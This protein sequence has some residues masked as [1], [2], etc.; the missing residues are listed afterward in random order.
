M[1]TRINYLYRDAGN[2][3]VYNSCVISGEL[4]KE[5]IQIILSCL[6]DQEYFI[7]SKVGLPEERF[8]NYDSQLDH[9]WF[10]IHVHDFELT[11]DKSTVSLQ[12]EQLVTSF[13]RQKDKWDYRPYHD[14]DIEI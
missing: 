1:N 6:Y 3:K 13:R 10:E 14:L 11:N 8:S 12:P 7:P 5:Q 9:Q 2:N 4:T